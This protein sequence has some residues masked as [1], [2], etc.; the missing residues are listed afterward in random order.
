MLGEVATI[1][2]DSNKECCALMILC[3]KIP[4]VFREKL[5]ENYWLKYILNQVLFQNTNTQVTDS[6]P[7]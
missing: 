2:I 1:Y 6:I 5:I 7:I 4:D 3:M